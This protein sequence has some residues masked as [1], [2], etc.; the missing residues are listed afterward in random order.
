M[1]EN[2]PFIQ[3]LLSPSHAS[4]SFWASWEHLP[5]NPLTPQSLSKR[6]LKFRWPKQEKTDIKA[7]GILGK[8]KKLPERI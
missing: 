8:G 5:K 2:A 4:S 3:C 6:L 1:C 7:G